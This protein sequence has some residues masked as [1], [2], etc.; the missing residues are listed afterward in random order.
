MNTKL[1]I[2]LQAYLDELKQYAESITPVWTGAWKSAHRTEVTETQIRLY[3]A[4]DVLNPVTGVPVEV[5]ADVWESRG[6]VNAV[7][8]R[9]LEHFNVVADVNSIVVEVLLSEQ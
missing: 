5:Y 3:V 4:P 2:A 9:V 7:Y 6:G 8:A 1:F